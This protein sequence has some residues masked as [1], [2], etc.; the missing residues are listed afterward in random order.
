M[1]V[2]APVWAVDFLAPSE[3][4]LPEGVP[5][6]VLRNKIDLTGEP[7]GAVRRDTINVSAKTGAGIDALR[8]AIA[9][10]A[11]YKDLGEGAFAARQRH[12]DALSTAAG[13]FA[14]GRRA[15][16]EQRAGELLAEELRLS[17]TALGSITGNVSSDEFLGRIFSAFCIGK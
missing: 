9:S 4:H 10:L 16:A 12:I 15:L 1:R 11:G 8:T 17:Q 14:R 6:I 5:V 13:H 7:A 3:W 2:T